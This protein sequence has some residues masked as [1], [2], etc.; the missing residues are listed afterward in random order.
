MFID[1]FVRPLIQKFH[2]FGKLLYFL[3]YGFEEEINITLISVW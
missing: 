1:F 2:I 3:S